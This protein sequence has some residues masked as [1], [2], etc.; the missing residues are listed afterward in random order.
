M[1]DTIPRKLSTDPAAATYDP[2]FVRIAVRVNG[3]SRNDVHAYDLDENWVDIRKRK[4]TDWARDALGNYE[5]FR[6]TTSII[7]PSFRD[8]GTPEEIASRNHAYH[9]EQARLKRKRKAAKLK[10]TT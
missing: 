4:G 1:S 7:T 10:G 2:I 6:L 3:V 8:D 9:I 5:T